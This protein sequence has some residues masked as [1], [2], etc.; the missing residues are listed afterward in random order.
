MNRTVM[1]SSFVEMIRYYRG[2]SLL[3]GWKWPGAKPGC[4]EDRTEYYAREEAINAAIA[5]VISKLGSEY[6]VEDDVPIEVEYGL[7]RVDVSRRGEKRRKV[8]GHGYTGGDGWARI[9]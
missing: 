2:E 1:L 3:W 5:A 9:Y 8:G 6:E 7:K 4:R